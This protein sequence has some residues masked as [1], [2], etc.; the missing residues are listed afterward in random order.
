MNLIKKQ[1]VPT[2]KQSE[3]IDSISSAKKIIVATGP[4]GCGKTLFACQEASK[5]FRD[6]EY[7]RIIVTRPTVAVD[8]DIGY[9][10]GGI[11]D[12]LGPW[13]HPMMDMLS[14][15]FSSGELERMKTRGTLEIAPLSFMRGRTFD[16]SFIIA[17]EMQNSTVN[18]M[19][20]ILTRIGFNSKMIV[21]GDTEQSDLKDEMSGLVDF[22]ERLRL[23]E[24]Q[25][26][27]EIELSDVDIKRH[28]VVNEIIELYNV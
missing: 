22:L 27:D 7:N 9:L 11:D 12:K 6:G 14:L 23:S 4:A 17:D 1:I 16:D 8:E 3:Y 2:I 26:I 25:F 5:G 10:P 28:P 18:Q 13:I 20:M 19:K 15:Y 21:T 24:T